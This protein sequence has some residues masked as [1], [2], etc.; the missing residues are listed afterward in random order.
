MMALVCRMSVKLCS[1]SVRSGVWVSGAK[2]VILLGFEGVGDISIG[3]FV[4]LWS[5]RL[6]CIRQY[7]LLESSQSSM[8]ASCS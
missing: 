8:L 7:M 2:M 5:S 4:A 6:G 3:S 1:E